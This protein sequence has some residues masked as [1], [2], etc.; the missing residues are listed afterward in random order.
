M[1]VEWL[2]FGAVVLSAVIL[3]ARTLRGSR[4][5]ALCLS[6]VLLSGFG[7]LQW[8]TRLQA[9]ETSLKTMIE[10]T[11]REGREGF[12]TSDSCR[13]CHPAQ[14][15]SWHKSFHR[16]MTQHATS[17]SV[18]GNFNGT[19]LTLDG[20]QYVFEQRGDEFWCEMV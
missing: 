19:R 7:A 9:R 17:A 10:K 2:L 6:A 15:A 13:S 16:T 4:K 3:I 12:V 8:H 20:E 14:Y 11:P 5:W 1:S 18:R